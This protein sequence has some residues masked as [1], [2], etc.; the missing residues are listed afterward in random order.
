[1][2]IDRFFETTFSQADLIQSDAR[3][4]FLGPYVT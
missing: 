3:V 1:M 4:T 2:K